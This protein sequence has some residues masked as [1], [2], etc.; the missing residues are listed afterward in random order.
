MTIP[1]FKPGGLRAAFNLNFGA[2]KMKTIDIDKFM[3]ILGEQQTAF[4]RGQYGEQYSVD[5]SH[6]VSIAL[7]CVLEAFKE[8]TTHANI[9]LE[10]IAE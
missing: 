10:D 3:E 5:T 6:A 2:K 4:A 9:V 1:P 7:D 8:A